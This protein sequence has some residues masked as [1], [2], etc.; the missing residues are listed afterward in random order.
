MAEANG[1][2]LEMRR[3]AFPVEFDG[4]GRSAEVIVTPTSEI[5]LDNRQE[6]FDFAQSVFEQAKGDACKIDFAGNAIHLTINYNF[7]MD[8]QEELEALIEG[9]FPGSKIIFR[10]LGWA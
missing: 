10:N 3:G 1:F 6:M 2:T 8:E 7:A 5:R 4:S 9:A